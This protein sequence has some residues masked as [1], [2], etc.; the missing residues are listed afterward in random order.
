MTTEIT[1]EQKYFKAAME[2]LF[3]VSPQRKFPGEAELYARAGITIVQV[4]SS[5]ETLELVQKI[6][7]T[8]SLSVLTAVNK[9]MNARGFKMT[10]QPIDPLEKGTLHELVEGN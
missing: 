8:D 7:N 5:M 1:N 6:A 10:V 9:L 2:A 4:E 3:E